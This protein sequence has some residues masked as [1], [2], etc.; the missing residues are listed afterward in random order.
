MSVLLTIALSN[1]LVA[2]VF[3]LLA[4]GAARMSCRPALA[5][6][7]WLL[8][9]VK[10][11]TPPLFSVPVGWIASMQV[12][13]IETTVPPAQEAPTPQIVAEAPVG[14]AEQTP[15]ADMG[16]VVE[17][18][19]VEAAMPLAPA[20]FVQPL[21]ASATEAAATELTRWPW[22]EACAG[23]WLA[24]S[25]CWFSV[26]VVRL[27][28]FR[29]QLGC[30]QPAP[31]DLVREAQCLAERLQ[32]TCPE[33]CVVPGRLSPMLWVLG[34]K[35]RL[36]VP[37]GLLERLDDV[38]RQALLA[39]E[40]AH[41]RRRDHWVRWLELAALGLYWWC[42]LV[43]WARRH[44]QEAEEECCDAWVVWLMP[45]AARGYALALVETVDFMASARLLLPPVASGIGHVRLLQRRLTMI[46]RGTTPRTLTFGGGLAVLG[47]AALLLPLM[48]SWA[49]S[50]KAEAPAGGRRAGQDEAVR[51]KLEDLERAQQDIR[52]LQA[53]LDRARADL[54]RRTRDLNAKMEQL[55]KAAQ[56]ADTAERKKA[57]PTP[58]TTG[59][60]P[61][62]GGPAQG[63]PMLPGQ[64]GFGGGPAPGF[65]GQGGI[66]FGGGGFG[67]MGGP[68]GMAP[69]N[70]ANLEKRLREVEK[71]L[72]KLI[73][74]LSPRTNPGAVPPGAG[75][76]A[77]VDAAPAL[78]PPGPAPA[79]AP[80]APAPVRPRRSAVPAL[81]ATPAGPNAP[82]GALPDDFLPV[83][84]PPVQP[85]VPVLPPGQVPPAPKRA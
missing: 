55:K 48:P 41:W 6:G 68:G 62:A 4:L 67:A 1:L 18:A 13:S 83:I 33:V 45:G 22:W 5:H 24:G 32:V 75:A 14:I 60:F 56:A 12:S 19:A 30:A 77:P 11:L 39:H 64:G 21:P 71:K 9:F 61:G 36:L 85:G 20:A 34:W 2:S 16:E 66:G 40:L 53:E 15:D 59:G 69:A 82:A 80:A 37:A 74:M 17:P 29:G 26:A 76:V 57:Q 28:R 10:L 78:A 47:L 79:T 7:L 35:P 3:A 27:L 23:L 42:P 8:F 81:P 54:E 58:A 44:M 73:Q 49:Q 63:L 46:M 84:P 51:Q 25:L 31:A 38:Q 50:P 43:W 72:D 52:R 65:P 70:P